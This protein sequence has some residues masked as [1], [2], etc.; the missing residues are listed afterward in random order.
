LRK[1][2]EVVLPVE[3]PYLELNEL[4]TNQLKGTIL[5]DGKKD[6]TLEEIK[7]WHSEKKLII[8]IRIDGKVQGWLFLRGIPKYNAE[9]SEIYL[10]ELDY[11]VNTKNVLV[12]S[13]SW[14]LSGKV[15]KLI[16]ENSKYSIKQDLDDMKKEMNQQLNGMKPHESVEIKFKMTGLSFDQLYMTDDGIITQFKMLALMGAKIG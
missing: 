13:L 5:Y 12:K 11:H 8:A 2:I 10:D 14:M 6:V 3:T 16:K 15:L 1:D 4:F 7:L 9:T